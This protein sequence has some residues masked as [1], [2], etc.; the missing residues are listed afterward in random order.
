MSNIKTQS[1]SKSAAIL[2]SANIITTVLGFLYRI[3]LSRAVGSH[4]LGLF[5]LIM[6]VYVI[7]CTII[8]TGVPTAVLRLVAQKHTTGDFWG[9]KLVVRTA[10]GVVISVSAVI[11]AVVFFGAER[12]SALVGAKEAEIPLRLLALC[13]LITGFEN[14]F[15]SYF[16]AVNRI[17]Q[18]A[19]AE[20][21]E[22]SARMTPV[23]ALSAFLPAMGRVFSVSAMVGGM[24]AGEFASGFSLLLMFLFSTRTIRGAQTKS[25]S[26]EIRRIALPIVGAKLFCNSLY[27]VNTVLIP[28][29]LT[30]YGY[31]PEH[32]VSIL[33][34]ITGMIMPLLALPFT[35]V[36]A[37]T[38]LMVPATSSGIARARGENAGKINKALLYTAA[39]VL[40]CQA[41][42]MALGEPLCRAVYG[43]EGAGKLVAALGGTVLFQAFSMILSGVLY[44]VDGHVSVSLV[45]STGAVAEFLCLWFLTPRFGLGGY[46][47]GCMLPPLLAFSLY[48]PAVKRHTGLKLH[49]AKRSVKPVLAAAT[50]F[51][52]C[53]VSY[54]VTATKVTAALPIAIFSGVVVYLA[55]IVF[56]GIRKEWDEC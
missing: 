25:L 26:A 31:S 13:I 16:Y 23:I 53:R 6:P 19:V 15:K 9:A 28:R 47:L 33:G 37:L 4:G 46:L 36:G 39:A 52:V 18:P 22:Q 10:A 34:E 2:T 54:A 30:A 42:L 32:S 24:I 56:L 35:L 3:V 49:F 7:S 50:A 27:S 8:Q 40:P 14:I 29:R 5:G 48:V 51:F 43:V 38:T 44:G 11:S 41:V 55:L 12:I 1:L 20:I 17:V 21:L 45:N